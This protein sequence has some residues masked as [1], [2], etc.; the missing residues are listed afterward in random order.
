MAQELSAVV[1]PDNTV[2]TLLLETAIGL[3]VRFSGDWRLL[4]S[5]STALEDAQL[6]SVSPEALE[7]FDKADM[8]SRT[9]SAFSLPRSESLPDGT[10]VQVLPEPNAISDEIPNLTAGVVVAAGVVI[11]PVDTVEDLDV[12]IKFAQV[13]PAARWYVAKRASVLGAAERV[14]A[15]WSPHAVVRPFRPMKTS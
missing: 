9:L 13:H 3:Y 5:D 15:E 8:A 2:V 7:V 6:L 1:A 12:A 4:S 11:P 10:E 14:P